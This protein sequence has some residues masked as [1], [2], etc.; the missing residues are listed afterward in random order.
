MTKKKREKLDTSRSK[1]KKKKKKIYNNI[2][3]SSC[4]PNKGE[5]ERFIRG[6]FHFL[7]PPST[8]VHDL[9]QLV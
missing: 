7:H 3:M 1:K 2:A 5:R 8:Y 9:D 4:Y 6:V